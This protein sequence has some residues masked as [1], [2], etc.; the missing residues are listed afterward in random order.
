MTHATSAPAASTDIPTGTSI[1]LSQLANLYFLF[2]LNEALVL[3]STADLR[4][5][6][7]L[8]F[9]LLVADF[10]HLWS[11]R[12]LGGQVYWDVRQWGPMDIGNVPVVYLGASLRIAFL[13]GLGLGRGKKT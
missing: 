2:T 4:V 13:V 12:P 6:R 3:R 11:L 9:G 10:G 5:W 8:L 1:V 7:T